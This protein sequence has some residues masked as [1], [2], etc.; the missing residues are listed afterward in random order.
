[1]WNQTFIPWFCVPKSLPICISLPLWW[2]KSAPPFEHHLFTPLI[3][4]L[5]GRT[6]SGQTV[7]AARK[8]TRTMSGSFGFYIS[9]KFKFC[10]QTESPIQILIKST[11]GCHT[12][13][14]AP[15][16]WASCGKELQWSMDVV[17]TW[18]SNPICS[19]QSTSSKIKTC[20]KDRSTA[21]CSR[22]SKSLPGVAMTS[23]TPVCKRWTWGGKG[24]PPTSSA[25]FIWGRPCMSSFA[26]FSIWTPSSLTGTRTKPNRDL[27]SVLQG[28]PWA[29]TGKQAC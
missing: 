27:C 3:Y 5:V 22:I 19:M 16:A 18:C 20:T 14:D 24:N 23:C 11:F 10:Y 28:G 9:V 12:S 1:M 21:F 13:H 29:A 4:L 8:C 7:T 6:W 17:Q 25:V 26:C 2:F 15:W